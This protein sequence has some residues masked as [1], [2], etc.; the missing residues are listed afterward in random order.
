MIA[1]LATKVA[2]Y[3]YSHTSTWPGPTSYLRYTESIHLF[4]NVQRN[5]RDGRA[6]WIGLVTQVA[7]YLVEQVSEGVTYTQCSLGKVGPGYMHP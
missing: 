3:W 2:V 7:L 5:L 1:L 4:N 6:V